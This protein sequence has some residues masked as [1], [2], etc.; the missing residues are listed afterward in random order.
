MFVAAPQL[1][2][3]LVRGVAG[4]VLFAD[5]LKRDAAI[6]AHPLGFVQFGI[7][8]KPDVQVVAGLDQVFLRGCRLCQLGQGTGVLDRWTAARG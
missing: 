7:V 5:K 8:E 4:D 1:A 3:D 6:R 2:L